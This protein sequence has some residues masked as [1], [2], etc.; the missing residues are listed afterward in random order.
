MDKNMRVIG[1]K[2]SILMGVSMSLILSL[3][4]TLMGGH[5]T[6]P[7]WLISFGVSLVISLVIG[8]LIPMKKVGDW[9]CN[10]CKTNPNSPKGSLLAAFVSDIIYTPVITI[11]MV[12]LM[13]NL[14][15]KNAP[16]GAEVPTV[17]QVLPGSLIVCFLV[18][19]VVIAILTP[20]FLKMLMKNVRR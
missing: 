6:I 1:M 8:F 16:E 14:A 17:G 12:V 4:G 3:V 18:G 11:S 19:Y 7:S 20:V 15:K 10:K 5:F 13:L 2:M 9:F